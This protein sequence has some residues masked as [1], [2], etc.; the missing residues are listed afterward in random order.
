MTEK[1]VVIVTGGARGIGKAIAQRFARQGARVIVADVDPG[2]GHRVQEGI[3]T[4]ESDVSDSAAVDSMVTDV[5]ERF[6]R[7]DVM[8]CNAGIGGGA[9]ITDF[10]DELFRRIIDVNLF[11]VFACARAA[12]RVMLPQRSGVVITIGSVFG[13]DAPAGTLAYAASKAGVVAM[14]QSLAGSWRRRGSGSTASAPDTSRRSCTPPRSAAGPRR[15]AS[16]SR[17]R[18]RPS[19]DRSRS[20]SSAART[21]S[22]G[23]SPSSHRMMPPTSPASASTSTVACSRGETRVV[24]LSG[25]CLLDGLRDGPV[26]LENRDQAVDGRRL[27]QDDAA[28]AVLVERGH[29]QVLRPDE[30]TLAVDQDRLGVTVRAA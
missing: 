28:L 6:G 25:A 13:Q 24:E 23:S 21:T 1:Q 30:E 4:C 27:G 19:A 29:R 18:P 16:R 9:A 12:A 3:I 22:P 14:T 7:L 2:V 20:A 15:K 5:V 10:D 17:R 8:V 26:G 11:G